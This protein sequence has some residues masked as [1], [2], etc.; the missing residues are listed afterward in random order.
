[1]RVAGIE[2]LAE[3]AHLPAFAIALRALA[4][5]HGAFQRGPLLAARAVQGV[6]RPRLDQALDHAPVDAA[7][8]RLFAELVQ[9]RE[10]PQ[11]RARLADGFH[12]RLAEVLDGAHAEADGIAIDRKS[13]RLN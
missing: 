6:H 5:F 3:Q 7:Q 12:R 4:G 11:L 10:T 1:M 13:T 9:R 8:I 2:R